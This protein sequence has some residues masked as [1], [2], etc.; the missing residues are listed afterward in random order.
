M[1]NT[2]N[3]CQSNTMVLCCL[4]ALQQQTAIVHQISKTYV[5]SK[6]TVKAIVNMFG[7][8]KSIRVCCLDWFCK[9]CNCS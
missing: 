8:K 7:T 3:L 9:V 5:V 2:Y 4:L 6:I 1:A